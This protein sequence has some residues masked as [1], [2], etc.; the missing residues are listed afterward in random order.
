MF[1]RLLI[2]ALSHPMGKSASSGQSAAMEPQAGQE[3]VEIPVSL[4]E[5]ADR[6]TIL[7][8]KAQHLSGEA[9]RHVL[10]ETSLLEAVLEPLR[11]RVPEGLHQELSAVNAQ[12]WQL[13]DA[14]RD[15]ERRGVFGEPFVVLAR[16]IYRLNDRRAALKRA[17]SVAG[18]SALIEEKVYGPATGLT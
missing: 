13:E 18:G 6:L 17:I 11:P 2:R 1:R 14:V 8:L 5:L 3:L 12:L 10:R 9:L 7:Q 4:G 15:C 16:S